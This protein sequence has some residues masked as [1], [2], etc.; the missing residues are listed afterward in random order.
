[1]YVNLLNLTIIIVLIFSMVKSEENVVCSYDNRSYGQCIITNV[2][3]IEEFK[4]TIEDLKKLYDR[5][6]T[7]VNNIEIRSSNFIELPAGSFDNFTSLRDI[8]ARN[9]GLVK[10]ST[11]FKTPR[12]SERSSLDIDFSCNHLKEIDEHTFRHVKTIKSLNLTFNQI[13]H[14]HDKAFDGVQIEQLLL[15]DNFI[16]SIEFV[17]QISILR[18]FSVS[19]N[20]VEKFNCV[21]HESVQIIAEENFNMKDILLTNCGAHVNFHRC[22]SLSNIQIKNDNIS[23]SLNLSDCNLQ[24]RKEIN[25]FT[26]FQHLKI[27]NLSSTGISEISFGLLS[28]NYNLEKLEISSNDFSYVLDI[29]NFFPMRNLRFLDI[30]DNR[31]EYIKNV[32]KFQQV[33]PRIDSVD[34]QDNRFNCSGLVTYFMLIEREGTKIVSKRR[35][36]DHKNIRGIKCY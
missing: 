36:I 33:F 9:T 24:K 13:V 27:L 5:W 23:M 10:I 34:L 20:N 18:L 7:F 35:E 1:M 8:S 29:F 30:S 16:K 32:E 22:P 12:T 14:I 4:K 25:T 6:Q 26:Q 19:R 31:I 28:S 3:S 21:N 15:S 11:E 2:E 17:N